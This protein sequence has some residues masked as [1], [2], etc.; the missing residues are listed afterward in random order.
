MAGSVERGRLPR[1]RQSELTGTRLDSLMLV[2]VIVDTL[3]LT[4]RLPADR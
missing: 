3:E 4:Q 2:S 1:E